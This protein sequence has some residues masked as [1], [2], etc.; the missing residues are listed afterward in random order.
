MNKKPGSAVEASLID[1][2]WPEIGQ[3]VVRPERSILSRLSL[4]LILAGIGAD[5]A[6]KSQIRPGSIAFRE[7]YSHIR[8]CNEYIDLGIDEL[9]LAEFDQA[10]TLK[11]QAHRKWHRA[12]W[13]ALGGVILFV[14]SPGCFGIS[15]CV[16]E[17]ALSFWFLVL[18]IAYVLLLM[19]I[20]C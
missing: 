11:E 9:A 6:G 12:S 4:V 8:R 16:G 1:D 15:R 2:D 20:G 18:S 13:L 17:R 7:S 5:Y 3:V 14:V 19:I 10:A